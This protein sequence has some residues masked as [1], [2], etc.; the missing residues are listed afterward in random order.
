MQKIIRAFCFLKSDKLRFSK[1]I[2]GWEI[3]IEVSFLRESKPWLQ[4]H[5]PNQEAENF[6]RKALNLS[7]KKNI[8]HWLI[9][10]I[11]WF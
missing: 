5:F 4:V 10:F 1:R 2:K 8:F 7:R 3:C 11:I 9:I 6:F